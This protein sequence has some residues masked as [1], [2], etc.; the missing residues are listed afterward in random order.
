MFFTV[1]VS[2]AVEENPQ[3]ADEGQAGQAAEKITQQPEQNPLP[4]FEKKK[5][6][7]KGFFQRRKEKRKLK[8]FIIENIEALMSSMLLVGVG[9]LIFGLL[10][11]LV[12][13][14][15]AW[16]GIAVMVIG[17]LLVLYGVLK[18]FF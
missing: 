3:Q 10:L 6:K 15:A 12:V 16:L 11:Y 17:L 1:T 7:K 4:V 8:K 9:L 13:T 5:E 2:T 14:Q 18:M